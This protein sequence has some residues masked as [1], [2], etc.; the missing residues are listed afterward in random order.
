MNGYQ[1]DLIAGHTDCDEGAYGLGVSANI[2]A[3][4]AFL[5]HNYAHGDLIY[6]FGFS[7]GAYTAR[8]IAGLITSL[9]LLT[10]RGMDR[11]PEVYD[12]YYRPGQPENG[13]Q[14][15]EA[16]LRD[17]LLAHKE[18]DET[19]RDAVQ[20]I[21]VF[22]TVGFVAEGWM[23]TVSNL[24][25]GDDERPEFNN[26]R[27]SPSVKYGYH[28]LALD[29]EREAFAPTLWQLPQA[30]DLADQTTQRPR[31]REM[32]QVWFSGVHSDIGGG[33]EKPYL[34][35]IT[36]AWMISRCSGP[37]KL[38]FSDLQQ[39]DEWYLMAA[40]TAGALNAP[41]P[42]ATR[43]DTSLGANTQHDSLASRAVTAVEDLKGVGPRLP[44][45][46][47]D[48][49][50]EEIHRSVRDRNMLGGGA[51]THWPCKLLTGERTADGYGIAKSDKTLSVNHDAA[52]DRD[53][54]RFHGRIRPLPLKEYEDANKANL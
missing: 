10:K 54:D 40:Q 31:N 44:P 5:A 42:P 13:S 15:I 24:F 22:D 38:A 18:L 23:S 43:W 33:L 51:G 4:Y 47:L 16:Y 27:L 7:R 20:V 28:A 26:V 46:T 30:S 29:E 45:K 19:A 34:S 21:G 9:G 17:D 25:G 11:F 36:L 8:G 1:L 39:N 52:K 14:H 35:D 48:H 50:N 41:V 32:Q 12:N 37:D 53:E 6:C 3:A 2:R 49:T